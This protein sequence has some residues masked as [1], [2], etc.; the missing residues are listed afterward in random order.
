MLRYSN[1]TD[2]NRS[3]VYKHQQQQKHSIQLTI[4]LGKHSQ[5]VTVWSRNGHENKTKYTHKNR[6]EVHKHQQQQKHSQ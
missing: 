6:S 5:N 1:G 4:N 2:K 3:E